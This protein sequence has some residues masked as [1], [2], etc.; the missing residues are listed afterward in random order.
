MS[1]TLEK[2]TSVENMTK[3]KVIEVI[4]ASK[5]ESNGGTAEITAGKMEDY[6]SEVIEKMES[7]IP[8]YV[9][10]YSDLYK[11]YL[12]I[13]DNFCDTCNS[14]QKEVLSKIGINDASF[15]IFD[16]YL[17]SVK[18]MTLLQIDITESMIKNYVEY[19]LAA[20]DFYDKTLNGSIVNFTN[21]LPKFD[22]LKDRT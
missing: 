1:K 18:Q 21:T 19:R 12:H 20:L 16:V 6:S 10:L 4:K 3:E 17:K 11:K 13:M 22:D 9:K 15:T 7:K 2:S 5:K 14:N 8:T